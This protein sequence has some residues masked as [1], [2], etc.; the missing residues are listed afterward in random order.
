[1]AE[2]SDPHVPLCDEP[3]VAERRLGATVDPM[4]LSLIRMN[5]KKWANGTVLHYYFFDNAQWGGA[6]DQ[7]QAV[8]DAFAEWKGL[9]IG[10][11]F[12]E[13]PAREEAEIRIGFAPGGSWSYV[14]RD[15]IDHPPAADPDQRTMN[16]GWDLTTPYGR[17]TAL[18]EIGHSLGFPHEHQNPKAGIVWDEQAVLDTFSGPPNNWD[19]ARIR[20]NILRKLPLSEVRG[21][22]W[23][24]DSIMHYRFPA[25]V[26]REPEEY[27][28]APLVPDPGL[29]PQD[30]S[31]A[32]LFYPPLEPEIDELR[33]F[34]SR[35]IE[36]DP[37]RQVNFRIRPE[38][39]RRYRI[40][41]FGPSDVV[42]VLF[43]D[44]GGT[45]AYV[46]GDDDSGYDRNARLSLRLERG[47]AYILRVRLY[48]TQ[49][50]GECAVM[51]W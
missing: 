5:E 40:Q 14:G 9:G 10:L 20:H 2:T 39:S 48:W 38:Y 49:R 4:R 35:H 7:K 41:T 26:I 36:I 8:R 51:L 34:Q 6:A 17:D 31:Q 3:Y 12:E 11:E 1:M 21:S 45:P 18:H 28:T 19:A 44:D 29:S 15:A 37:G 16:F 32:R 50:R 27:R 24:P 13:V 33:P 43:E 22:E 25:G 47:R 46:D 23:D 30:E 42:M